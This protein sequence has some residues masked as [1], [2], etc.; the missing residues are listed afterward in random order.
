LII[1]LKRI[2]LILRIIFI[3]YNMNKN[4]YYKLNNHKIY[5][6]KLAAEKLEFERLESKKLEAKKLEDEKLETE[7][8]EAKKLEAEKLE[9][10]K[11]EFEK[12]EAKKFEAE[13][14]EAEKLEAKKLVAKKLDAKKLDAQKLDAKKLEVKKIN[15][16]HQIDNSLYNIVEPFLCAEI[17][18]E[19][20]ENIKYNI[21]KPKFEQ[22]VLKSDQPYEGEADSYYTIIYVNNEYRLYYRGNSYK[23]IKNIKDVNKITETIQ[24]YECVCLAI[25]K[26]GLNFNKKQSLF[27]NKF[28]HNFSPLYLE[29]KKSYIAISG[30][31]FFNNGIFLLSSLNGLEWKTEKK[32]ID[33]NNIL[34]GYHHRN[35]YD[36]LNCIVYNNK[37]KSYYIYYRHNSEGLRQVQY[38]ITKDFNNFTKTKLLKLLDNTAIYTPGIFKYFNSNYL[39]ALPT[40]AYKKLNLIN[41]SWPLNSINHDK[42]CNN[43]FISNDYTNFKKIE[44]QLFDDTY[45]F[46]VNGIVPSIDNTKMYIYIHNNTG[47]IDNHVACYSYS[48]HR[49]HQIISKENGFIKT[50]LINLLNKNIS[51]NFETY[52][53]GHIIVEIYD[54]NNNLILQSL[55]NNGN[56]LN[57]KINWESDNVIIRDDYYIK[58]ILNNACLYSFI[59]NLY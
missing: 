7:K 16:I 41:K 4:L 31:E 35:H 44:S 5:N 54:K 36:S 24:P 14:L 59:Y 57:Y 3:L 49:M 22:I 13:K 17:I 9:A 11:L 48:M 20:S 42:N 30:T 1:E 12:L 23:N 32:I 21:N 40:I 18:I 15:A 37:D 19:K 33:K 2:R 51:I 10:E 45:K 27:K 38:T 52:E 39:I 58:F 34:P 28:C 29:E 55:K 6:E 43:L 25:S 56:E 47:S 50:K 46:N 26:D 53:N 8:L